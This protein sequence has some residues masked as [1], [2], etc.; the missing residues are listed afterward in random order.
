M[1]KQTIIF[2]GDFLSYNSCQVSRDLV[3]KITVF[4]HAIKMAFY[5]RS[6]PSLRPQEVFSPGH[7]RQEKYGGES[8][9]RFENEIH[10]KFDE[11][12]RSLDKALKEQKASVERATSELRQD[13]IS[14]QKSVE[15]IAKTLETKSASASKKKKILT[16]LSVRNIPPKKPSFQFRYLFQAIVKSLHEKSETTE[17]FNPAER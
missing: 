1:H 2:V 6:T 4:A 9:S 10:G 15:G 3:V 11:M 5:S 7:T 13:I 14:L 12:N 16:E 17:Q 8:F